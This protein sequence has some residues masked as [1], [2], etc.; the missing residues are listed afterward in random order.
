[1][2]IRVKFISVEHSEDNADLLHSVK[3]VRSTLLQGGQRE[4]EDRFCRTDW[5]EG[6]AGLTSARRDPRKKK[7]FRGPSFRSL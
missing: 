7:A 5:K 2:R 1:M 3:E 6:D 4:E